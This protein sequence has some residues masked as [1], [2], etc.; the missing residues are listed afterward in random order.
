MVKT[1]PQKIAVCL[2]LFAGSGAIVVGV[3]GLFLGHTWTAAQNF[4]CGAVVLGVGVLLYVNGFPER[5]KCPPPT[6]WADGRLFGQ[7]EVNGQSLERG[8]QHVHSVGNGRARRLS[9]FVPGKQPKWAEKVVL[10][11][12]GPSP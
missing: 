2:C 3:M 12:K 11:R 1:R 9:L 6:F 7:N 10:E 8:S 5:R 4:L